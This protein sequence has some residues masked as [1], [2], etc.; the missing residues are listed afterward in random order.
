MMD[1]HPEEIWARRY[2]NGVVSA[3]DREKGLS[4]LTTGDFYAHYVRADLYT[5]ACAE[6]D[7]AIAALSEAAR[8]RGEAEGKLAAS[9][10]AGV[11]DGWIAR[12]KAA[13]A[14]LDPEP[15][16]K[17]I[18]VVPHASII[19]N[20]AWK[21][22]CPEDPTLGPWYGA[23][24]QMAMARAMAAINRTKTQENDE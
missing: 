24:D 17:R 3:R 11:L 16:R 2:P 10:M 12:A 14:K 21:A 5:K 7:A 23:T 4:P 1:P 20:H 22:Y 9:E 15:P 19:Q 18:V 6:R 8:R 13:E